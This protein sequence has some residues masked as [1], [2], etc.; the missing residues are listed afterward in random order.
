MPAA[1]PSH[2]GSGDPHHEDEYPAD[3]GADLGHL[4]MMALATG[5]RLSATRASREPL[6]TVEAGVT[7][8]G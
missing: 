7:L 6:T 3:E 8:S 2:N 4:S 5:L 1:T